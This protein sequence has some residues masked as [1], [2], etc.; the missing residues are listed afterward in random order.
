[1]SALFIDIETGPLPPGQLEKLMPEFEAPANYKDPEKIK[2]A[3]EE[4][5]AKFAESAA[6]DAKTGRIVVAGFSQESDPNHIYT[7]TETQYIAKALQEFTDSGDLVIGWNIKGFDLPFIIQRCL[8]EGVKPPRLRNLFH[9]RYYWN[10]NIIDLMELWCCG[11]E[12][13][14]NGLDAVSKAFGLE[15]KNGD[16]KN[17]HRLWEE[18]R[19]AAFK[20]LE[21]DLKL[22]RQ[23]YQRICI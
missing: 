6:L 9:G 11:R 17:F 1:M 8:I 3:I 5:R 13:S 2:A 18:D 16:G 19:E 12:F 22:T 15:G 10:D 20:Y 21:N 23:L 14:G 4:K 7:S